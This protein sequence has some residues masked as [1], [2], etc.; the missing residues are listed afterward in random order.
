M[1]HFDVAHINVCLT[2]LITSEFKVLVGADRHRLAALL[3][4]KR[5]VTELV[6]S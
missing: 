6:S 2:T 1:C 4:S 5:I 3:K